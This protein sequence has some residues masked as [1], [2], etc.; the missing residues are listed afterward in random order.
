MS[1]L[2]TP[3]DG[4]VEIARAW[5]AD[6]TLACS[7]RAGVFE[8]LSLWGAVL[9]DLARYIAVGLHQEEGKDP[10]ETLRQIRQAFEQELAA[11][12]GDQP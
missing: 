2:H 4:A 9:A 8:D 12:P 7:V 10:D 6:D 1:E 11:P 3:P 5:L